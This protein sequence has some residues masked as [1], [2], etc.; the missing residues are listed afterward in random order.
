[1]RFTLLGLALAGLSAA[2]IWPPCQGWSRDLCE[3]KMRNRSAD[4]RD[5]P[6][7]PFHPHHVAGDDNYDP[8]VEGKPGYG[9]G[10]G[11]VLLSAGPD[12]YWDQFLRFEG[13]CFHGR[14]APSMNP[15]VPGM[16]GAVNC[17]Y[18]PDGPNPKP[19]YK[20]IPGDEGAAIQNVTIGAELV[21][22]NPLQ[23]NMTVHNPTPLPITFWK[24][25]SPLSKRGWQ[26]GYYSIETELWGHFFGRVGERYRMNFVQEIPKR[27][28]SIDE[29]V[30]LNPGESESQTVTL[31]TCEPSSEGSIF[32]PCKPEM[33]ERAIESLRLL[34]WKRMLIQGDWYGIWAKTKEEAFG[35]MT[36]KPMKGYWTRWWASHAVIPTDDELKEFG[37][38]TPFSAPWNE[39]EAAVNGTS[40]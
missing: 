7:Y 32:D 37:A 18:Y 3:A 35:N 5:M 26:L 19:N 25:W 12:S 22:M 28:E 31:F 16:G 6:G 34:G 15:K 4:A 1:M 8:E 23:V 39:T 10:N 2:S 9:H 24:E 14:T 30:Q 21:S 33:W 11:A 38:Y 20:I 36:D 13:G 29:L 40:A 27:P 17:T